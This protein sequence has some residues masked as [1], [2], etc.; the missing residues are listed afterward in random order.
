MSGPLKVAIGVVLAL[1]MAAILYFGGQR[2][3][4][5]QQ[6]QSEVTRL[7]DGMYRARVTADRCQRGLIDSETALQAFNER[8][9]ALRARVDSFEALDPRGVP[10]PQYDAYMVVFNAYNDSVAAYG[11]Q[12]QRARSAEESCREVIT[13][14]NTLQDSLQRILDGLGS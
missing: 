5:Q 14:H 11:V 4:E 6:I 8:L 1:S 12:E 10:E 2:I 9:G 13:E 3:V 7:R